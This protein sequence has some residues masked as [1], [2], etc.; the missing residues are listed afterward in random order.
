MRWSVRR[1]LENLT[2]YQGGAPWTGGAVTQVVPIRLENVTDSQT[3]VSFDE[4]WLA[5]LGAAN[6]GVGLFKAGE[7]SATSYTFG[8]IGDGSATSYFALLDT[9][10]LTPGLVHDYTLYAKVGTLDEMRAA[11][12]LLHDRGL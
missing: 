6:W 1:Y 12:A 11:F 9:F 5:Y 2:F 7:D 4:N 3:I 8:D 10:A